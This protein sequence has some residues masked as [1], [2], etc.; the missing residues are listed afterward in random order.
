MSLRNPSSILEYAASILKTYSKLQKQFSNNLIYRI[1]DIKEDNLKSPLLVVQ[2]A[3][4]ANI[5]E[6]PPK[7]IAADDN[8]LEGFSKKDIRTITYLASKEDNTHPEYKIIEQVICHESNTMSYKLQR[9]TNNE[10]IAKSAQQISLDKT[11]V[12]GLKPEDAHSVGYVAGY[13]SMLKEKQEIHNLNLVT[14]NN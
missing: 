10:I 12:S 11:L 13:E 1:I 9:I 8:M 14:D 5:F 4:K 3:G 6:V 2:V 7:E